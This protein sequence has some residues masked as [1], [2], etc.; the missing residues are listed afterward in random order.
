MKRFTPFLFR[1]GLGL[2]L[3]LAVAV[4][5]SSGAD[6]EKAASPAD[7]TW[8]WTFTMPD[9]N[10]VTPRA[11][12]HVAGSQV[13]GTASYGPGTEAAITNGT[14]QGD[15]LEFTVVRERGGRL[16]TTKYH[17]QISGDALQGTI[18]SDWAG[19]KQSYPWH[20]RR[21]PRNVTGVWEWKVQGFGGRGAFAVR[22]SFK[23][24]GE[25][26]TGSIPVGRF[27]GEP[28]VITNGVFTNGM[29]SFLTERE[30]FGSLVTSDYQGKLDGDSIK[31]DFITE[32]SRGVRTNK[33]DAIRIDDDPATI[34]KPRSE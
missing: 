34:D 13:T 32:S 22:A 17:G 25:K 21:A 3:A 10:M 31:G 1:A 28:T 9:G 18:E 23:Q 19:E 29:V 26:F 20:A 33:W 24:E 11:K 30:F 6:P 5:L 7:G 8:K 16:A 12:L 15:A 4:S 14:L 2:V 27:G